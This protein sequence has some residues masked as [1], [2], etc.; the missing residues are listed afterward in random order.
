MGLKKRVNGGLL[1]LL[2]LIF[3]GIATAEPIVAEEKA[4]DDAALVLVKAIGD[5]VSVMAEKNDLYASVM[6]AQAL[7]ASDFGKGQLCQPSVNNLFSIKG[8]F[9]DEF[10]KWSDNQINDYAEVFTE[11]RKYPSYEESLNDYIGLIKNGIATAP[12]F[13]AGSWRSNTINYRG[14]T[15]S[16]TNRYAE[17]PKYAQNLNVVIE[18]YNLTDFDDRHKGMKAEDVKKNLVFEKLHLGKSH[19]VQ[20][21]ETLADIAKQYDISVAHLI[22]SNQL[23]QSAVVVGQELVVD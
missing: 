19:K 9:Q 11:Y 5:Q 20:E 10:V 17:D 21:K 7:L 12:E 15:A 22:K 6:M 3:Y 18:L 14:A 2:A 8:R 16:L 23:S 4:P 1:S 13:Y